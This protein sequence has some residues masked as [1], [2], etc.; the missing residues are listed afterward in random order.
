MRVH[1][2]GIE[3]VGPPLELTPGMTTIGFQGA[4]MTFPPF[5]IDANGLPVTVANL[6]PCAPPAEADCQIG[7]RIVRLIDGAWQALP[8]HPGAADGTH[9][10]ALGPDGDIWVA[11][12]RGP[13]AVGLA[14][15]HLGAWQ[16]VPLPDRAVE[17]ISGIA[18]APDGTPWL[19]L[20]LG[21]DPSCDCFRQAVA[22]PSSDEWVVDDAVAGVPLGMAPQERGVPDLDYRDLVFDQTGIP[23]LNTD[24]G[25][26]R[27]IGGRWTWAAEGVPGLRHLTAGPDGSIWAAGAGVHR[28]VAPDGVAAQG[29]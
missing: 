22:R 25:V 6:Q 8:V 5:A 3:P 23:Y 1:D 18:I 4:S 29:G 26:A 21:A 10:I 24:E 19:R 12:S 20:W 15:F 11:T 9:A 7:D 28:L 16:V 17:A 13:E 14:R 2:D 27:F